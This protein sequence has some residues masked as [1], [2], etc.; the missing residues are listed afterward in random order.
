MDQK[1]SWFDLL[2][3]GDTV[4]DNARSFLHKLPRFFWL[5]Y[6]ERNYWRVSMPVFAESQW[7]RPGK[8]VKGEKGKRGKG[9]MGKRELLNGPDSPPT[10]ALFPFS[11]F[12]H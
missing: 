4:D 1:Q 11:I 10:V 9:G 8:R 5:F 6:G 7:G 12:L 3:M 2:L